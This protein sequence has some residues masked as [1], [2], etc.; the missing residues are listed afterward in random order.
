L[1]RRVAVKSQFETSGGELDVVD[2][3]TGK[4]LTHDR[5]ELGQVRGGDAASGSIHG[6]GHLA[7]SRTHSR[8]MSR[9][10][11]VGG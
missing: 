9:G 3:H 10:G 8:K 4:S 6:D 1:T 11:S 5:S 7:I 2:R